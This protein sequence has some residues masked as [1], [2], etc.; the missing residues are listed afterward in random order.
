MGGTE[1]LT[2][3]CPAIDHDRLLECEKRCLH[4]VLTREPPFHT[5][6]LRLEWSLQPELGSEL[7]KR[8]V[9]NSL[10][11]LIEPYLSELSVQYPRLSRRE[12]LPY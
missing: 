1:V 11:F 6:N 5:I 10:V 8:H 7:E 3:A 9:G 12:A 4:V 2:G